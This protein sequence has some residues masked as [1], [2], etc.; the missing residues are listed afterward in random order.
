MTISELIKTLQR[1]EDEHGDVFV[2]TQGGADVKS[3]SRVFDDG[4]VIAVQI[5]R[6]PAND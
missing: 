5:T 2:E 6:Y 1:L 4:A 3:V